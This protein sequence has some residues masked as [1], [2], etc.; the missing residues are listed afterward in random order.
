MLYSSKSFTSTVGTDRAM[1]GLCSFAA[2]GGYLQVSSDPP[3]NMVER[4]CKAAC[5]EDCMDDDGIAEGSASAQ[6]NT[7]N[8]KV[9]A[10]TIHN[11]CA[12]RP[13]TALLTIFPRIHVTTALAM[14]AKNLPA[15]AAEILSR[16]FDDV[17]HRTP[18]DIMRRTL[19]YLEEHKLLVDSHMAYINGETGA[20]SML[21]IEIFWQAAEID[22]T[23][24]LCQA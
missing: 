23:D 17:L 14:I 13:N 20:W 19:E 21:C 16:P 3:G 7:A 11:N 8:M 18:F 24:I 9:T 5:G 15:P 22:P 12:E 6:E 10:K 4:M 2:N 1:R